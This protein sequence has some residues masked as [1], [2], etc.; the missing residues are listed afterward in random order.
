MIKRNKRFFLFKNQIIKVK[1][2]KKMIHVLQN[3]VLIKSDKN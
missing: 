3:L 2:F 1:Y